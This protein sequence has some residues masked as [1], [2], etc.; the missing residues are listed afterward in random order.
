M[1]FLR[2]KHHIIL[3]QYSFI[4]GLQVIAIQIWSGIYLFI[5]VLFIIDW[6]IDWL[7]EYLY[8]STY[9]NT[10]EPKLY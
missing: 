9:T 1:L 3:E 5:Y 8:I 6:L 2:E 4:F 7:N 10:F